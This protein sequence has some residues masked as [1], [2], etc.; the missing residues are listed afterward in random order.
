MTT[1]AN[2]NAS[3]QLLKVLALLQEADSCIVQTQE[4]FTLE[5]Q[6]HSETIQHYSPLS[7]L[8]SA[9][10]KLQATRQFLKEGR[11]ILAEYAQTD[12]QQLMPIVTAS[13]YSDDRIVEIE[14]FDATL[15]FLKA[16]DA[17]LLALRV[18]G[19]Q[20]GYMAD[21]V[22]EMMSDYD[23]RVEALFAHLDQLPPKSPYKGFECVINEKEAQAWIAK[24]RPH[25]LTEEEPVD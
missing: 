2:E 6:H 22:A 14:A 17:S 13:C 25:L 20:Q 18:E 16:D 10:L 24:H 4:F 9:A 23:P 3:F 5:K 15:W 7:L 21:S 19:Y 8:Q 12:V 11:G 1:P